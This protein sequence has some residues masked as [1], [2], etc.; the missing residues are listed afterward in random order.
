MTVLSKGYLI[1]KM[2]VC[3][4]LIKGLIN[5]DKLTFPAIGLHRREAR[6][7]TIEGNQV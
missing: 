2:Y 1:E 6:Q 7:R 5:Y 4:C 3:L